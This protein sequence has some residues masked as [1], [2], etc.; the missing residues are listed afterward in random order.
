MTKKQ[1]NHRFEMMAIVA[2]VAVVGLIM[3]F[4]NTGNLSG[5]AF[6]RESDRMISSNSDSECSHIEVLTT[7][8]GGIWVNDNTGNTCSTIWGPD[9][10]G[11][12]SFDRRAVCKDGTSFVVYD[13]DGWSGNN[14]SWPSGDG[15]TGNSLCN[16][17][18]ECY[19][20]VT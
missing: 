7:T 10:K 11:G 3:M 2:I 13:Q 15:V 17:K 19:Q 5:E 9:D 4:M 16:K 12:G 20:I 18:T 14:P 1:H 6:K 8:S